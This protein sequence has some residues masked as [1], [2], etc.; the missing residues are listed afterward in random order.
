M[1]VEARS[2]WFV[3]ES[4]VPRFYRREALVLTCEEIRRRD[5]GL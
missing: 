2:V 1:Q 3:A 4:V 5:V